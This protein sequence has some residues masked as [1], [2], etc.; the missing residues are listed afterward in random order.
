M[1]S[2]RWPPAVGS[3]WEAGGR[4]SAAAQPGLPDRAGQ[5]GRRAEQP[6]APEQRPGRRREGE[7]QPD[8]D[9]P[10]G[11]LPPLGRCSRSG[12]R[13]RG[14][15]CQLLG[16]R[17][18]RSSCRR[19]RSAMPCSCSWSTG[20]AT[21]SPSRSM[22]PPS[23][24]N[25]MVETGTPPA[26]PPRS[27]APGCG[28]RCCCRRT[29]STIRAGAGSAASALDC[30]AAATGRSGSRPGRRRSPRRSRSARPAPA[31]S[32]AR[33]TAARSVVGGTATVAVPE[34]VTS[35]RLIR[36]GSSADELLRRRLRRLPAGWA[37]RPRPAW[38]ATRR[39]PSSRWPGPAAPGCPWSA[40]PSPRSASEREQ[41]QG[42]GQV[43]APAGAAR[44][45]LAEQLQV[46]E[47][48]R[49][50]PA[51]QLQHACRAPA[52]RRPRA[53]ASSQP[54]DRKV[55][56]TAALLRTRRAGARRRSGPCPRA[57]PGRSAA[58]GGPRRPG[59]ARRRSRPAAGPPPPRT[60][61][62]SS[63]LPV[64]TSSSLPALRVD[65]GEQA[66]RRAGRARTGSSTSTASTS[67][68]VASAR[69]GR[70]QSGVGDE[71]P[72]KSETTTAKPAPARR[73]AQ[74]LQRAA[75][76]PAGRARRARRERQ[77][78][79]QRGRCARGRTWPGSGAPTRR[80]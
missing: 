56:V 9:E 72:R 18:P 41:Q 32:I 50:R 34:K 76:S 55:R 15:R 57:S 48:D 60:T 24:P 44:G 40:W 5:V 37:R 45:Q 11:D 74:R 67:C 54:G 66:D 1:E 79:Q 58:A 21:R 12:C 43:P 80:W 42:E 31:L 16:G 59:A 63:F 70:S 35:P 4:G 2:V 71:S 28:P 30:P 52:G 49:V 65:E 69:S 61:R 7:Q 3:R 29:C 53:A 39:S 47:P 73:P 6:V 17:P 78:V 23:V 27:P 20:T 10:G 13:G 36:G 19:C 62:R 26:S 33:S 14:R 68:R 64:C 25:A 75:R 51:A 77:L 8:A 38:T 22:E 46:G